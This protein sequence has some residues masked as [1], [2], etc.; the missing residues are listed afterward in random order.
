M[1]EHRG[2]RFVEAPFTGSKLAAEKGELVYY[3][4][5]NDAALRHAR[6]ILEASSKK[7]IETGEIGQA[8]AIKIATNMVPAASVQAAAEALGLIQALGVPLQKFVEAMQVNASH[9][10]TLAM[11]IPKMI[12]ANFEP[13]F[14]VKHM[15]KDMQIANRLGLSQDLE[16]AVTAAARDQLLE[17][18]EQGHGDNDYSAVA[19]KH[20]P[21]TEPAGSEETQTA[22]EQVQTSAEAIIPV[23]ETEEPKLEQENRTMTAGETTAPVLPGGDAKEETDLR[24]GFLRQL[25]RRAR[26]LLKQ[27]VSPKQG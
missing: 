12:D 9:S 27:P 8:S 7:I 13:H 6:P 20:L 1:V 19:R 11:K 14:S 26:Q 4:A 10:T 3:V 22:D 21:K 16:L 17:Q 15:L 18:I 25:L 23:P 2:G 5:G 24:R